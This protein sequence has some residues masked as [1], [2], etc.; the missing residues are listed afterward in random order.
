M[1]IKQILASFA[2]NDLSQAQDFYEQTLGLRVDVEGEGVIRHL[3]LHAPDGGKVEVYPKPDFTPAGFTVMNIF[4]D[5][6]DETADNF[7][8]KGVTFERYEGFEHDE[9]GI[10]RSDDPANG[11][12]IAWLKDPAGNVF[13]ILEV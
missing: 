9:K 7:A 6:I 12:T 5:D 4:V 3:I 13:A 10:V 1:A 8:A 2:V 11:P